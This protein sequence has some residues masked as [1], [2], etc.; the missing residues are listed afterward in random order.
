MLFSYIHE[1]NFYIMNPFRK[2]GLL[3]INRI[4]CIFPYNIQ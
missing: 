4:S 3:L 2:G 1:L